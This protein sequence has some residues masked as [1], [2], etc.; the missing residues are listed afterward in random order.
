MARIYTKATTKSAAA[1][2]MAVTPSGI[3]MPEAASVSG[4]D[5]DA[6]VLSDG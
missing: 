5:E 1:P 6:P 2:T 3:V 4:E